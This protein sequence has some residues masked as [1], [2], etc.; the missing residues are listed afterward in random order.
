[1][2][3]WRKRPRQLLFQAGAARMEGNLCCAGGPAGRSGRLPPRKK[4]PSLRGHCKK[5][6]R[7]ASPEQA[8][9]RC[10]VLIAQPTYAKTRQLS[11]SPSQ[12]I[13]LGTIRRAAQASE[14]ILLVSP[15]APLSTALPMEYRGTL[16]AE[17]R[18][19]RWCVPQ[20]FCR[21]RETR[22]DRTYCKAVP[23]QPPLFT[24]S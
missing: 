3:R 16:A 15:W 12:G 2:A 14:L 19:S 1:M 21:V 17:R 8:S 11:A 6:V 10:R 23:P 7:A 9:W 5:L 24:V 18:P 4:P 20:G 22:L 13:A